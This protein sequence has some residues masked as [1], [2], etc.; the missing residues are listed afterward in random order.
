MYSVLLDDFQK[1]L[2]FFSA[3]AVFAADRQEKTFWGTEY[4]VERRKV[5]IET[6]NDAYA[7][8]KDSPIGEE[9]KS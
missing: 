8:L 1:I 4:S 3:S 6:Q 5:V 2:L 7:A 9:E